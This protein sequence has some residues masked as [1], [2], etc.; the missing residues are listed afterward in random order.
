MESKNY[1]IFFVDDEPVVCKA[2]EL[3][4][5]RQE[6]RIRCFNTAKK[7]L[8]TLA[9]EDCDL[10]I[11]DVN[12]AGMNG[13]E[14]LNRVRNDHPLLPVLIITGYGSVPLAVGAIKAGAVDFIEKPLERQTLLAKVKAAIEQSAR[15]RFEQSNNLTRIESR[16][17]DLIVAGKCN[18]EIAR[19]LNRSVR[20]IEDHRFNIMHKL[21]AA[22]IVEL[23]KKVS[24]TGELISES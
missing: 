3:T 19:R 13:L 18:K 22:N 15:H 23:I 24:V 7:C 21:E 6:Y 11:T 4:L 20:T 10:L 8:D 17:L 1:C 2:V 5:Q 14:L 12:M 16:I 9:V